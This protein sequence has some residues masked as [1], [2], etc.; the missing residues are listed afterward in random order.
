M[1]I[2]LITLVNDRTEDERTV[3]IVT[4]TATWE[5]V[6]RQICWRRAELGLRGY[7]ASESLLVTDLF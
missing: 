3:T 6:Q 4:R 5:D 1:V 2:H 7:H